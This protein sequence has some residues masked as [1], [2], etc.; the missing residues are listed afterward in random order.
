[1]DLLSFLER[2]R[3]PKNTPLQFTKDYVSHYQRQWQ[4]WFKN[5]RGQ[6]HLQYLEVGLYEGRSLFWMLENIL[7]HP[8]AQATA[9]DAYELISPELTAIKT[10]FLNNL[11]VS[12]FENKV[13]FRQGFSEDILPQLP[14]NFYDLIYVDG[15]HDAKAVESDLK[16]SFPLLKPSGLLV[17]D[18]YRY[19]N[20]THPE[21]EPTKLGVDRFL[22]EYQ[23]QYDLVLK[24]YQ[25]VV[26]KKEI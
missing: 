12:G 23:D 20:K 5:Y 26:R 3:K 10:T 18:D 4:S 6:P 14:L 2:W 11:K 13:R 15:N 17:I 19:V 8:T 25:V 16:I 21:I 24:D 9:V 1:M 7:T 22:N